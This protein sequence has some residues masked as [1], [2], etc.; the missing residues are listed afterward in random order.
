MVVIVLLVILRF[1]LFYVTI[2]IR[3]YMNVS[4]LVPMSSANSVLIQNAWICFSH[5]SHW[6][7]QKL[8]NTVISLQIVVFCSWYDNYP[9]R[10][11][12]KHYNFASVYVHCNFCTVLREKRKRSD[13]VLRQKKTYTNRNVKRAKWQHKQ[14]NKKRSITQRLRT[15]FGRSVGVTTATQLVW[16]TGLRAQPTHSLQ[17]CH[18]IAAS[19]LV[20]FQ[21][22][23]VGSIHG[24]RS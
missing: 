10:N 2:P 16:L 18:F 9:Q 24:V 22:C 4:V 7:Y 3:F 19:Q 6:T 21:V 17:Q 15:D 11:W 1:L 5:V 12:F 8:R 14:R 13:S 23:C 20:F